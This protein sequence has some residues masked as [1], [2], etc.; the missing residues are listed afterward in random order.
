MRP[1][2]AHLSGSVRMINR[3]TEMGQPG[4]RSRS[5]SRFS[6]VCACL[7]GLVLAAVPASASDDFIR[8][9]RDM[10]ETARIEAALADALAKNSTSGRKAIASR[11]SR[12]DLAIIRGLTRPAGP[13]SKKDTDLA[14][15]LG[16]CDYAGITIRH[17]AV[18]LHE[19]KLKAVARDAGFLTTPRRV[20]NLFAEN[21]ARCE[22]I[23]GKPR[24][25][26]KIGSACVVTATCSQDDED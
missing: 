7:A 2:T 24:S 6:G 21:V 17:I 1:G 15:R 8:R 14:L 20:G 4:G 11:I 9:M 23:T 16:P 5:V 18:A 3:A 19:N 22:M 13:G 26:R 12:Q 25:I 10:D